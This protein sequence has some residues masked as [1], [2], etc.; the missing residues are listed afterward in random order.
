MRPKGL[1]CAL[2][3]S[4]PAFETVVVERAFLLRPQDIAGAKRHVAVTSRVGAWDWHES[5]RGVTGADVVRPIR[6]RHLP[7]PRALDRLGRTVYDRPVLAYHTLMS[8]LDA[9]GVVSSR[10]L[11]AACALR[12]RLH[13]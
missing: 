2:T 1:V 10:G 11:P 7:P 4:R 6:V 9:G 3:S 5:E 8:H 12:Q 13:L